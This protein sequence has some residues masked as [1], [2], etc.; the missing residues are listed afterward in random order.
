MFTCLPITCINQEFQSPTLD[1]VYLKA[2]Q[3]SRTRLVMFT[4][5]DIV[6][7]SSHSFS[8]SPSFSSLFLPYSNFPFHLPQ[9][10]KPDLLVTAQ[11]LSEVRAELVAVGLR[12]DVNYPWRIDFNRPDW[13]QSLDEMVASSG[14][15]H[16]VKAMDYFMF[17]AELP[18]RMPPFLIGRVRWDNWLVAWYTGS[19]SAVAVDVTEGV[20]AIHLNSVVKQE[21]ANRPGNDYNIGLVTTPEDVGNVR[22][23]GFIRESDLSLTKEGTFTRRIQSIETLLLQRSDKAHRFVVIPVAARHI[24]LAHNCRC[25][26]VA[27]G[28]QNYLFLALD[29]VAFE[30]F[31]SL[32]F[33]TL[34][35]QTPGHESFLKKFDP[36]HPKFQLLTRYYEAG[37]ILHFLYR[38]VRKKYSALIVFPDVVFK[39]DPFP[40]LS[41]L[42]SLQGLL[43]PADQLTFSFLYLRASEKTQ[44]VLERLASVQNRN[45]QDLLGQIQA[46]DEAGVTGVVPLG[47]EP[48][49]PEIDDLLSVRLNKDA[50]SVAK[51]TWAGFSSHYV[52][53]GR[54]M[55]DE[56]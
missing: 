18:P 53:D 13:G 4:N 29:P 15:L 40:L 41:P 39:G 32:G 34:L 28:V 35:Y 7:F 30:E 3:V 48:D 33:P 8:P 45:L 17:F 1:C 23:M 37:D 42:H 38:A 51:K 10:Y 16:D 14:V 56:E 22:L 6:Y 52:A 49:L 2:A 47:E 50:R 31:Y 12:M 26:L 36:S 19:K 55:F 43:T 25:T 24:P 46:D 44:T 54:T 27:S 9:V 11:K 5:S 21:S 20:T